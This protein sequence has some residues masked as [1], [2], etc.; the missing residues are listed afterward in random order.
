M[1]EKKFKIDKKTTSIVVT[2]DNEQAIKM[3]KDWK[4]SIDISKTTQHEYDL[5]KLLWELSQQSNI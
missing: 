1:L 4:A 2:S 5:W 3:G